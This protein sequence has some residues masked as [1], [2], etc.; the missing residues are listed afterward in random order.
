MGIHSFKN[1]FPKIDSTVYVADGAQIIGDVEIE[2]DCSVWFNTV[3]RGD[4]NFIRIGERTNIQDNCV[5]H[6]TH[7]K[8][9]CIIKS[10][11]T[12]GHGAIIHACT[13]E[14]FVLV[15]MNATILDGAIIGANSL[16]AAGAVI[17]PGV[18]I[19]EGVLASGVPA[20]VIRELKKEEKEMLIQSA[21]NYINYVAEYRTKS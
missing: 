6:V 11:V 8:F 19:P 3:I 2:K 17:T 14:D 16:I 21:Q 12:I 10:N 7:K 4:V 1:I 20:K 5:V 9:P 13:I 15:G 18:K